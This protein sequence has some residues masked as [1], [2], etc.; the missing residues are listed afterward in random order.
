MGLCSSKKIFDE[1]DLDLAWCVE[2][3]KK[4]IFACAKSTWKRLDEPVLYFDVTNN[5]PDEEVEKWKLSLNEDEKKR[6]HFFCWHW[7]ATTPDDVCAKLRD[8]PDAITIAQVKQRCKAATSV[9]IEIHAE[10][11]L[12]DADADDVEGSQLRLVEVELRGVLLGILKHCEWFG[13]LH[14]VRLFEHNKQW[15]L[16]EIANDN[17]ATWIPIQ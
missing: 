17:R 4:R 12:I 3:K 9:K 6:A 7:R 15:V 1:Y 16:N 14:S 10:M 2:D 5:K 11:D 13:A 8:I